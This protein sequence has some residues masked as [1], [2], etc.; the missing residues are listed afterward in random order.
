MFKGG[1][2]EFFNTISCGLYSRAAN[3]RVNTV[4]FFFQNNRELIS[5]VT[6]RKQRKIDVV[7]EHKNTSMSYS[8]ADK[9]FHIVCTSRSVK[10]KDWQSTQR[11]RSI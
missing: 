2:H 5:Y 6:S 10:R 9:Y 4:S 11:S 8:I 3:N 7:L 1:L